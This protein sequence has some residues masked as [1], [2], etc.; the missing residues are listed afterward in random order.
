[1][2]R[3]FLSTPLYVSFLVAAHLRRSFDHFGGGDVVEV[4][5]EGGSSACS[6]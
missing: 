6:R 3:A 5:L 1:M 4:E 2:I